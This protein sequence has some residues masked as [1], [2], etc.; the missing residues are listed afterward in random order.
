MDK[1]HLNTCKRSLYLALLQTPYEHIS[2]SDADIM[3]ILSNDPYIQNILDK[4]R[5]NDK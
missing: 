4:A 2:D 1:S 5:E 3:I